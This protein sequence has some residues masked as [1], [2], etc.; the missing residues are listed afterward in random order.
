MKRFFAVILSFAMVLALSA[1]G[2]GKT[3]NPSASAAPPDTAA[4]GST[5][6]TEPAQLDYPTKDI[7]VIV[8]FNA[9]GNAD[10]SMRA[11]CNTANNLDFFNGHTLV[12][13]N[14]GGGGAVIGQTQ[15]FE[16]APDGYTLMLYTGSVINNDIFNDTTYRYN[17]FLPIAGY[18]PDSET[19]YCPAERPITRSGSFLTGSCSR[20]WFWLLRPAILPAT[21]FA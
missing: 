9:G 14:V 8:P 7:T 12:V 6:N 21:T 2:G 17:D 1:C 20:T 13:E 10:L 19:I 15:V 18:N 3:A 4:A 16:T 5:G 11:L